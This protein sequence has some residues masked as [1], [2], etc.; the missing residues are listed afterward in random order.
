MPVSFGRVMFISAR[1]FIYICV[2]KG[3]YQVRS[4]RPRA[5]GLDNKGRRVASVKRLPSRP[6]LASLSSAQCAC[7]CSHLSLLLGL[8]TFQILFKVKITSGH[9]GSA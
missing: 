4:S 8:T 7:H 1:L 5:R 3:T 6:S 2:H 9:V